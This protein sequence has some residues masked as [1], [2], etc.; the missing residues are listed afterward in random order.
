MVAQEPHHLGPTAVR[1][2]MTPVRLCPAV[3]VEVDPAHAV[4]G[5]AVELPEVEVA[6]AEVVV[7][8]VEDDREAGLM[9]GTDEILERVR[10]A[11][12]LLDRE[13]VDGL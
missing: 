2:R 5:P 8:D 1:S 7:D 11:E 3:L 12:G 4:L 9:G 10:T 6:R 13:D